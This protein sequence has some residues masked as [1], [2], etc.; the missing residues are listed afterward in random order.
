MKENRRENGKM[1]G[2]KAIM[3]SSRGKD[4]EKKKKKEE[5]VFQQH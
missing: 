4:D 1:E 2:N 3:T 5:S